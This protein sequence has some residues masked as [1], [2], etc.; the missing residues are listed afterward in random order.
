MPLKDVTV[1]IDVRKAQRLVALG[2]PVILAKFDG[3]TTYT[4]YFDAESVAAVF[5]ADT[6]VHKLAQTTFGQ[7]AAP[8]SLAVLTYNPTPT[9]PAEATTAAQVLSEHFAEDFYFVFADTQVVEEVKAIADVVEGQGLKMFATT[10]TA[11]E[12]LETLEEQK[13]DRT[14]APFHE[15][16]GEY[17]AEG[18]AA[19]HGSKPVGSIT[20]KF[21]S[22]VGITPQNLTA[23]RVAEIE[24]LNSFVYAQKYGNNET[25]EGTVLSGE[26][27]DVIHSKDWIAVNVERAVQRVFN[28][29]DKVAI[30]AAGLALI[31]AAIENVMKTAGQQGMLAT[32]DS[33]KYIYSIV[34]PKR[35]DISAADRAK[36]ELNNVF[37]EFE[38]S[39]A[40]HS[41]AIRA[42]III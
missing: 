21:K 16:V 35:T 38:L 18:L 31:E 4:T 11:L 3:P 5:G 27:I 34:M 12:A 20:Y 42:E 1:T 7:V 13:Y 26:Y 25:S 24:R 29:N 19:A 15:T 17:T 8:E 23:A 10:T 39:G 14:F 32:D 22:I 28:T 37:L 41:A 2:K 9:A 36:R 30:D 6:I 40:V 33:G